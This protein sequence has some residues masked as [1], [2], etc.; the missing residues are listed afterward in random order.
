[1]ALIEKNQPATPSQ[2]RMFGVLLA[3]FFSLVGGLVLYHSSSWTLASVIW[4]AALVV[5]VFYYTVKSAQPLIFRAWMAAVYPIGWFISHM[6]LGIIYYLVITPIGFVVRL[7]VRDPLQREF[8]RSATT[9][10]MDC[11]TNEN[12]ERYFQQF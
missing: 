5:C 7:F 1:M 8:D 3:I 6:L 2:L 9:Y 12:V 4:S 11:R 10:W